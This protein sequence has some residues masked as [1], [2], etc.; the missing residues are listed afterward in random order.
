MGSVGFCRGVELPEEEKLES[1]RPHRFTILFRPIGAK[2]QGRLAS[3]PYSR[4]S[5][6]AGLFQQDP[7]GGS[8][9]SLLTRRALIHQS[10]STP[11]F[12]AIAVL[13]AIPE[14]A[15]V[16]AARGSGISRMGRNAKARR[17]FMGRGDGARMGAAN[18]P[19]EF[20]IAPSSV[21]FDTRSPGLLKKPVSGSAA[22]RFTRRGRD[23]FVGTGLRACPAL[24]GCPSPG[25]A[26]RPVPTMNNSMI[27][28][29]S[30]LGGLF[31]AGEC[32]HGAG[33]DDGNK[34]ND[35]F[36]KIR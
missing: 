23:G 25:Q 3:R 34:N 21:A 10:G 7:Q 22:W 8:G 5:G 33:M 18:P 14:S 29:P 28:I 30:L 26:R 1:V 2:L 20:S 27:G 24:R 31:P 35:I 32:A 13:P 36:D 4:H 16:R 15:I 12:P 6:I 19:E 17:F 9:S 11:H